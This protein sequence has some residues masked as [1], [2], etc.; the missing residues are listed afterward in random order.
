MR[1]TGGVSGRRGH[2][3]KPVVG[4]RHGPGAA[5]VPQPRAGGAGAGAPR[6]RQ[7]DGRT[8]RRH[9]SRRLEFGRVPDVGRRGYRPTDAGVPQRDAV[10]GGAWV[11]AVVQIVSASAGGGGVVN[12]EAMGLMAAAIGTAYVLSWVL[13]KLVDRGA[14]PEWVMAGMFALAIV[15]VG[16]FA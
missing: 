11:G 9:R 2:D 13:E 14:H 6:H 12:W 16:V 1:S 3:G 10:S 8:H 15:L 7:R 5:A 4:V